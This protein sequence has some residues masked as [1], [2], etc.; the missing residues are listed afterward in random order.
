GT[1]GNPKGVLYENRST[2]LHAMAAMQPAA[3]GLDARTVMLPVVPMFHAASW[4]LPF[5]GAAAGSKFVYSATNDAKV[6]CGLF[7]REKV[8]CAA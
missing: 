2:V 4:G 8:T 5:A 6:L 1:T 3:L 7:Q